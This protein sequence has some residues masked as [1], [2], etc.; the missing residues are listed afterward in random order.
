MSM[1]VTHH[2]TFNGLWIWICQCT[3]PVCSVTMPNYV[4][5]GPNALLCCPGR[6]RI[7]Q[8]NAAWEKCCPVALVM[9][10]PPLSLS[11]PLAQFR[12]RTMKVTVS[13]ALD[14][15]GYMVLWHDSPHYRIPDWIAALK[16]YIPFK[17]VATNYPF[18]VQ[19]T[20]NTDFTGACCKY[21]LSF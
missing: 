19:I 12:G 21:N 10:M 15:I 17:D 18:W 9:K 2:M 11:P 4:V 14:N 5:P 20:H 6:Y 7:Q 16:K 13:V 8:C 1:L 3:S